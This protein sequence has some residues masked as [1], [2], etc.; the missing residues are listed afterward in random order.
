MLKTWQ[1][2]GS[3]RDLS[4]MGPLATFAC[5]IVARQR[6]AAEKKR[7]KCEKDS[8]RKRNRTKPRRSS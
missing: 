1:V 3:H 2:G 7:G 4:L 6:Q 5:D 8:D